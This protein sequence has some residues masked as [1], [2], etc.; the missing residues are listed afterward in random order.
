MFCWHT[1][2][3]QKENRKRGVLQTFKAH[4]K[5]ILPLA[6]LHLL[7][8]FYL[9]PNSATYW[10][11]GIEAQV[12]VGDTSRSTHHRRGISNYSQL[13]SHRCC[14]GVSSSPH[15]PSARLLRN[16]AMCCRDE[17][18]L[19]S[20][21]MVGVVLQEE[22]AVSVESPSL[23]KDSFEERCGRDA[24]ILEVWWCYC[25]SMAPVGLLN[26]FPV[27][28]SHVQSEGCWT[29]VERVARLVRWYNT[30]R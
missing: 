26:V 16:R 13:Q 24:F 5:D 14:C 15:L 25:E 2:I 22:A 8:F 20:W 4:P 3:R 18:G 28:P 17:S 29:D 23:D 12:P 30:T 9:P 7:K 21:A 1:G 27:F 10:R 19:I 11:P 6:R